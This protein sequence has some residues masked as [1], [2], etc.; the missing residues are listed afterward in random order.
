MGAQHIADNSNIAFKLA[1]RFNLPGADDVFVQRFNM[2]LAQSDYAGAARV[3]KDAPGTLLRNQETI[4]KFKSLPP[5]PGAQQQP[6][7]LYFSTLLD[8]GATLN[9][10]ES[11][12]LAGPVMQAGKSQLIEQWI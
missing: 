6:I 10:I 4:N 8:G 3:A 9:E 7:M 11:I 5:A 1:S 2:T 12:E